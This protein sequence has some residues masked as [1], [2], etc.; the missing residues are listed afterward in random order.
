MRTDGEKMPKYLFVLSPP[1]SGSTVLWKLLGT[2]PNVSRFPKEGQMLPEV[3]HLMRPDAWNP[4]KQL[5]WKEIKAAWNARWN[6]QKL[7]HIEKSPPNLVRA[8]RLEEQFSPAYFI[9]IVRDPYAYSEGYARRESAP[10]AEAVDSWITR[11]TI[12]EDQL[13]NLQNTLLLTYESLTQDPL[14]A[15]Q[16]ML[17]FMPQLKNLR[18]NSLFVCHSIAGR[19][20]R[21]L[22]NFNDAKIAQLTKQDFEVIRS[23][24][25][26]H[27]ELVERFGYR[28]ERHRIASNTNLGL[29][30]RWRLRMRAA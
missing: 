12:L 30:D 17:D 13:S 1:Y 3:Q 23:A 22:T 10:I 15:C 16:K 26:P 27:K 29:L 21:K 25:L 11:V 24:L 5:A 9:A 14:A 7:I 19:R 20:A 6:Q 18:H 4:N 28:T 8:D 2:S